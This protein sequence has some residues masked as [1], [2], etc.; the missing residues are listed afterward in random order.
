[1]TATERWQSLLRKG[2]PM[3]RIAWHRPARVHPPSLP[4]GRVT[5]AAPPQTPQSQSMSTWVTLLLP[6]LSSVSIAAYMFTYHSPMMIGLA[7]GVVTLSVGLTFG[8]RLEMR[9]VARRAKE[10]HRERYFEHLADVRRAAREV[11]HLQRQLAVWQYPSPERLRAIAVRRRRLWERRVG[12]PDFLRLRVGLGHAPL[13]TPLQLAT[14]TDPTI[15]YEPESLV[16][17]E[18]VIEMLGTV[19]KQPA[20]VDL[21][22]CGVVSVVGPPEQAKAVGRALIT[23][24]TTLHAPDDV[25][26]V[27]C[28]GGDAAAWNW[29]AWLPHTRAPED[30][31][32]DDAHRVRPPYVG[33]GFDDLA[34]VLA[35]E[36]DQARTSLEERVGRQFMSREDT[37]PHRLVVLVD[38]YD[39]AS[40]W[41]RS[42]LARAVIEQAGP[43]LGVT[44]VALVDA[45]VREPSRVDVRIRVAKDGALSL[46]GRDP[47]L[48]SV[49]EYAVADLPGPDLCEAAA[50]AMSPLLLSEEGQQVL[51][52]T[53]SLAELF[54][55]DDPA[56]LDPTHTWA[57]PGHPEVLR[58]PLGTDADGRDLVLD[59]KEAAQEGMGPH[60]LIVG[61][62]GSGKSELLRTLVTGLT[63]SHS[64]E[65]L[66]LVLIDFK[67]GATF[68]GV[69]ELPHVAGLITN[70]ADDLGLVDR[71]RDALIGEQQRR[72]QLLRDA[73]NV[74]SL[75]DY[76]IRQ[77]AGGTDAA[78]RPLEPLPYLLIV[79]DEFGELLSARSD[80]IDLFVQIGRVGRSLGM[81]LL[82]ATQ[83]LEEG[84]LRGLESHLSYRICL[85]TFSAAESR[86][87]IGTTDAYTLP[88]IPGSAYLK[89]DQSVYTRFRVAHVSAPWLD[90]AAG[91]RGHDEEPLAPVPLALR[92]VA[93]ADTEAA[94]PKERRRPVLAQGGPERPPVLLPG[95]PTLMQILVR[96]LQHFGRPVH[97]I[98][99]PPL[100]PAFPLDAL[101]GQGVQDGSRGLQA[102]GWPFRGELRFPVGVVDVP[103]RQEQQPLLLDLGRSHPHLAL[104]GAPQSGKSVMLRTVV[105]SAM[106]THTP[107][108]LQFSCLD[109]GGGSMH[110]LA[111]APHVTGVAGR[112][113]PDKA[114]RMLVETRRLVDERER[115]FRELGVDSVA[116]FRKLGA[117]GLLDPRVRAADL[118]LVID[119]WGAVRTELE[120]VE[121]LVL[122]LAGRGPGV[123]VHLMLSANRWGDLRMNLRDAISARLELRLN[124]SAESEVSRRISKLVPSGV[125]GRGVAPPGQ[126][127]QAA[128]PRLDGHDADADLTEAQQAAVDKIKANWAGRTAPKLRMLP[129]RIG[130]SELPAAEGEQPG[131]VVGIGETD[132]GPVR[133]D[134]AG[135]D[136]HLLVVGDA[137]SGKTAFLRSWMQGLAAQ[138]TPYQVRF[139]VVDY[140]RGLADAVPAEYLGAY[141]TDEGST[142]SYAAQLA[143]T[144]AAR[145]PSRDVTPAQ[146]RDRDWWQGPDLYLVVDDF[147]MV[148]GART[149]PLQPLLDYVARSR[150]VGF[151]LL[152]ARRSGGVARVLMS[153]PL[154]S[155]VKELG[156][157][158]LLLSSDPKEG[159][160]VH[161]VRG[162]EFP[163]GRGRL[164][165]RNGTELVQ[166]ALDDA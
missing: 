161:G 163:P 25:T 21:A 115:L 36:Y 73:G 4:D 154:V 13:S 90:E 33:E 117:E 76:Q 156:A 112:H 51:T 70:L 19:S 153:D 150:E 138:R 164:V 92:T 111:E 141:A 105:L 140:R 113:E 116:S 128:L 137:G 28:T 11:A 61:A 78:G 35:G 68:A 131:V 30:A 1:M 17:A 123:G 49:A 134:L 72:Q 100:P 149:S 102:S 132:L 96:Q 104:V 40:P 69:T 45:E 151:P 32:D 124:D 9:R 71:V 109:Y 34:E 142:S 56:T 54:G 53:V 144:L 29:T 158:G 106:L 84:R 12:D 20:T 97:Q 118:V 86:A 120:D 5:L 18:R 147:D 55:V 6:L 136:Q 38:D 16:A 125:P 127:F 162:A 3:S 60:G 133:L 159:P 65:Q 89:V 74:D 101:L 66:S 146:L 63:I 42:P 143:E 64:P 91:A 145:V 94:D 43:A 157:A 80:F 59:L 10:K 135:G 62:T 148:A 103:L 121:P 31:W 14:R 22:R 110:A 126:F 166:I 160:L 41:G 15:E 122:D 39:P 165:Q 24:L 81:H 67:G 75:R 129:S 107:E 82:L 58:V 27:V 52:R 114:R 8:V 50:R 98:W 2:K 48:R 26:L 37:A 87:V 23:Q 88:S 93:D 44:V 99:L 152:V 155:R 47:A 130:R 83:R 7:I 79:V 77:A 108:E 57:V 85:R 95:G 139:M 46:E 119:N